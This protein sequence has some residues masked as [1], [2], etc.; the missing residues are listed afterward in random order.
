MATMDGPDHAWDEAVVRDVG[1]PGDALTGRLSAFIADAARCQADEAD[2]FAWVVE[3]VARLFGV[4]HAMVSLLDAD[5]GRLHVA[6]ATE[7]SEAR[8]APSVGIGEGL[9]GHVFAT[10][11]AAVVERY[12]EW[13]GR[14]VRSHDGAIGCVM[15]APFASVQGSVAGVVAVVRRRSEPVFSR[16]E[17]DALLA[18]SHVIGLVHEREVTRRAY[19]RELAERLRGA[20]RARA[21]ERA[22]KTFLSRVSHELRTPLNGIHG[23]A[24]LLQIGVSDPR[25]VEQVEHVLAATT[26]LRQVLDDLS[27]IARLES[28]QLTV[29]VRPSRIAEV[30]EPVLTIMRA[31]AD[32][33]GRRFDTAFEADGD[34][35]L[36]ADPARARQVL[37][38]LVSNAVKY[39]RPGGRVTLGTRIVGERVMV[40]VEDTGMGIAPDDLERVFQPF[41]RLPSGVRASGGSGLGLALA[42]HL[43]EAM[44]ARL[45]VTSEEGVGSIFTLSMPHAPLGRDHDDDA[46][47]S[48]P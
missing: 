43:A 38:N 37:L 2:G 12:D 7:A 3:G 13:E 20:E 22:K 19:E 6:A 48:P 10:G 44:G 32:R 41:V 40:S 23:F 45:T 30:L 26:H 25:H 31:E 8:V 14:V 5:T 4:R 35:R 9:V 39:N 1:V 17:L 16:D 34:A 29:A 42:R 21:A 28:G 46:V 27:D 36:V 33:N 18:A 15:A 47:A 11:R 24:Q